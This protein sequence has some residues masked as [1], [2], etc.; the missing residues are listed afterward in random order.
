ML[1]ILGSFDCVGSYSDSSRL[2]DAMLLNKEEEEGWRVVAGQQ[3]SLPVFRPALGVGLF[4]VVFY[5]LK[6]C[7]LFNDAHVF[8]VFI[9]P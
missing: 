4:V 8:C 7:P 5:E 2:K 3:I 9:T 1:C 6:N